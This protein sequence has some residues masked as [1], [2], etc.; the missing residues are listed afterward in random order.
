MT[1]D[2]SGEQPLMVMSVH[3]CLSLGLPFFP[4]AVLVVGYH[5]VRQQKAYEVSQ[6][7]NR[8]QRLVFDRRCLLTCFTC[9]LHLLQMVNY[10]VYLACMEVHF[11]RLA[12]LGL[13]TFTPPSTFP[14][15]QIIENLK[16]RAAEGLALHKEGGGKGGG[17]RARAGESDEGGRPKKKTKDDSK[18]K[19]KKVDKGQVNE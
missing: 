19:K 9:V 8:R 4:T 5:R 16:K 17:K 15:A 7:H 18:K 2:G 11:N 6:S 13:G 12:K 14:T 1:H 3:R 10:Q